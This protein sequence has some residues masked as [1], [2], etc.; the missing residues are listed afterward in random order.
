MINLTSQKKFLGVLVAFSLSFVSSSGMA[1]RG[2]PPEPSAPQTTTSSVA[3]LLGGLEARLAVAPEDRDGWVLLAKSYHYLARYEE[4]KLAFMRA[5][6]LGS[7]E[8][9]SDNRRRSR[10]R[11]GSAGEA[12]RGSV[13]RRSRSRRRRLRP[14]PRV[15]RHHRGPHRSLFV[16]RSVQF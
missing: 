1:Q 15:A 8:R 14:E 7:G 4:A 5:R 16:L 10:F 6:E 2:L 11:A 9:G 3:D 13:F 12:R